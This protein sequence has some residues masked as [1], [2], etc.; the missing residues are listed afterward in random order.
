MKSH[1]SS[2]SEVEQICPKVYEEIIQ[3]LEAE[4]RKHIR[5]EQQ[6]KLHIESVEN[7]VEELE[8]EQEK[9][10]KS[11]GQFEENKELLAK[12]QKLIEESQAKI[13]KLELQKKDQQTRQEEEMLQMKKRITSLERELKEI[14]QLKIKNPE[15]DNYTE[16]PR[17][18]N[19][20]GFNSALSNKTAVDFN[21][22]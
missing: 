17:T 2:I 1:S 19:N 3:S 21:G 5:I 22:N 6:L 8:R 10:E 14:K 4:V 18:S 13:Q 7:R 15:N 12:K 11:K 9:Q 16:I 20:Q